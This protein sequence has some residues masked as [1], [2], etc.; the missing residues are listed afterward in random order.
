MQCFRTLVPIVTLTVLS[1]GESV[2]ARMFLR[3]DVEF[4][5]CVGLY[6]LLVRLEF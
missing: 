4:D 2:A 1:M 5:D 3:S 6:I